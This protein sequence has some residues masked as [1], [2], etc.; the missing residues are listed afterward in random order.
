MTTPARPVTEMTLA[1]L[2]FSSSVARCAT[3]DVKSDVVA[4]RMAARPDAI[5]V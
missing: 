3:T 2:G 4:L 1:P 5:C